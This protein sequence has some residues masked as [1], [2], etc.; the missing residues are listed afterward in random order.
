MVYNFL[1]EEA[2]SG[3]CP[4]TG[5][6]VSF[7]LVLPPDKD[8]PYGFVYKI[9]SINPHTVVIIRDSLMTNARARKMLSD[10]AEH[11]RTILRNY[12]GDVYWVD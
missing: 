12:T 3:L 11:F 6:P 8:A 5:E 9:N 4:I 2:K 1:Y 10:N 7:D